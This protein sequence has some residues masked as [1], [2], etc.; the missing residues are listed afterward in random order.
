MLCGPSQRSA[1]TALALAAVACVLVLPTNASALDRATCAAT[2]EEGQL[3]RG[4]GKLV[5]ARRAFSKCLVESCPTVV[6]KDCAQWHEEIAGSIPR[7]VVRVVD[8]DA[9]VPDADVRLDDTRVDGGS[10]RAIDVDPGTHVV[11]VTARDGRKAQ[12]SIVVVEGERQRAIVVRLPPPDQGSSGRAEPEASPAPGA[13]RG[14]VPTI[15]WVLGGVG[16]VALGVGVGLEVSTIVGYD[17]LDASPCGRTRTCTDAEVDP[18]RTRQALAVGA[19]VLGA[20]AL[21]AAGYFFFTAPSKTTAARGAHF[22][23]GGL[24]F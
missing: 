12:L 23:G 5:E 20:L 19:G 10:G 2:S 11:R 8:G 18:L 4:S 14:E 22:A 17:D 15:S 6:R 21:V 3:L 13:S 1:A 9:D 7:V 16:I 24:R